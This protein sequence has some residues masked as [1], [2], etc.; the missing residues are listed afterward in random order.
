MS[1]ET[2]RVQSLERQGPRSIAPLITFKDT[3]KSRIRFKRSS[4]ERPACEIL[5]N[6]FGWTFQRFAG[7]R[8]LVHRCVQPVRRL[9]ANALDLSRHRMANL[10]PFLADMA[11]VLGIHVDLFSERLE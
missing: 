8:H 10:T 2:K 4:F 5:N 3:L 6:S 7:E 9:P 1:G 11:V